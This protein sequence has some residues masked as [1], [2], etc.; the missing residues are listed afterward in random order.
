[1]FRGLKYK[2]VPM[3]Q[4]IDSIERQRKMLLNEDISGIFNFGDDKLHKVFQMQSWLFLTSYNGSILIIKEKP[5]NGLKIESHRN[6]IIGIKGN[7]KDPIF[8]SFSCDRK[9]ICWNAD[10]GNIYMI[11]NH[12]HDLLSMLKLLMAQILLPQSL[13]KVKESI[14]EKKTLDH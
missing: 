2:I 11:L 9:I 1:M 5:E 3:N 6:L 12:I 4:I 13:Q 14:C 8:V 10:N 7:S